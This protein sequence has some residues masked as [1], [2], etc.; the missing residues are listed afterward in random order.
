MSSAGRANSSAS[1]H[2]DIKA[3]GPGKWQAGH[4]DV[5]MFF[6]HLM[7]AMGGNGNIDRSRWVDLGTLSVQRGA[8]ADKP[9]KVEAIFL[10]ILVKRFARKPQ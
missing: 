1:G 7:P 6:S 10:H 5:A 2:G 4:S 3:T 8:R 9:G